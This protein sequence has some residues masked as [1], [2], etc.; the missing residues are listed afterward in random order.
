MQ[1]AA[2]AKG[3]SQA[4]A[5]ARSESRAEAQ[6]EAESRGRV[7]GELAEVRVKLEEANQATEAAKAQLQAFQISAEQKRAALQKERADVEV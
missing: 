3:T 4:V 2:A 1:L 5:S 7:E 6:A